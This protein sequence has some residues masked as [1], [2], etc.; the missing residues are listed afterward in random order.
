M[1]VTTHLVDLIQWVCFPDVILDYSKD[2]N[3]YNA[4]R[5]PT[6]VSKEQFLTITGLSEFHNS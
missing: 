2:V 5:W 4:R 6:N 3:V 1:D